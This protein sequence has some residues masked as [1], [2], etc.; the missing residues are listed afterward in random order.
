MEVALPESA[1]DQ[2]SR[3]HGARLSV[4]ILDGLH[5]TPALEPR[6]K[7]FRTFDA[8]QKRQ[9]RA[10]GLKTTRGKNPS[11][12]CGRSTSLFF[13]AGNHFEGAIEEGAAAAGLTLSMASLM[14]VS[15]FSV[16]S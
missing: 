1:L 9:T 13:P 14:P 10:E 12:V 3:P 4:W 11:K 2:M 5:A 16:A 15:H 8:R 6:A 7:C